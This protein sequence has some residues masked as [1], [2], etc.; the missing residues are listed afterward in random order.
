M[1]IR[2][3][4]QSRTRLVWC[5]VTLLLLGLATI[6]TCATADTNTPCEAPF[7]FP[8]SA[9]NVLILPYEL[10]GSGVH[11]P[12]AK[13]DGSEAARDLTWA[14]ARDTVLSARY[15]GL[16]V[17]TVL[18]KHATEGVVEGEECTADAI[19]SRLISRGGE[20]KY[21]PQPGQAFVIM[22]GLLYQEADDLFLQTKLRSVRIGTSHGLSREAPTHLRPLSRIPKA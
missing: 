3:L 21:A 14:L 8:D 20:D 7:V 18:P 4:S 9:V 17:I 2:L 19:V 10:A 22:T 1:P 6:T 16:G 15:D 5:S 13:W 12:D 11:N